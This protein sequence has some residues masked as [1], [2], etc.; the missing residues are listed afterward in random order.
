MKAHVED[1]CKPGNTIITV[2][3][4]NEVVSYCECPAYGKTLSLGSG[5]IFDGD[6]HEQCECGCEFMVSEPKEE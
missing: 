1:K 6:H 2:Q 4:W 5:V 3:A